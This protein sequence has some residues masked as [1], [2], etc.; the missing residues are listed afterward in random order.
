MKKLIKFVSFIS[1]VI[2]ILL[3][4]SNPLKG[5]AQ[6]PTVATNTVV[7]TETPG[8]DADTEVPSETSDTPPDPSTSFERPLLVISS[9]GTDVDR[10]TPGNDFTLK[11]RLKNDGDSDVYNLLMTFE[12]TDFLPL[13][14]GGV[15]AV[16]FLD[17]GASVEIAQPMR[18][19]A[20]LW[21]YAS[22]TIMASASYTDEDG[23]AYSE[24]FSITIDLRIP[25]YTT[26]QPT[27]MPTLQARAQLV[28]GG[29][30]VDVNPLQSGSIFNLTLDIRNL[31]AVDAQ[32]VTM[33]LGGGVAVPSGTDSTGGQP[34]GGVT[35]TGA[36]LS[37]FAPIG[38][39]NLIYLDEVGVG[40][41]VKA[42]AQLIVNVTANPG[43]Y[44]FKISFTY[45]N[46]KGERVVD[47]QV[48]TLLVYS[49]PKVEI[50]FYRNPGF[51][52]AGQM[53]PV[54]IQMTNLG[55]TTAVLGT[56]MIT[57]EDADLTENTILV[58]SL[59]PG[60]YFTMDAMAMPYVE[61]EM[62]LLVSVSYTDDFNQPR[63]IEQRLTVVVDPM[64]EFEPMPGENNGAMPP[65]MQELPE[66]FFQKVLRFFKGL[67]GLGS[68]KEQP[69]Q[70]MPF[71]GEFQDE[72]P[73]YE[74]P[75]MPIPGPKG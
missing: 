54:P 12:S 10:V 53:N 1:L 43:A 15:L 51:F 22:G 34:A 62:E 9:Y 59:E 40:Q 41:L 6:T 27:A 23:V 24:Q 47:D 4:V 5:V 33:V 70:D 45:L 48:I 20:S 26:P 68:G 28:V 60:G 13:V 25:V 18:A 21:G 32:D 14:S 65:P 30:E 66:T 74:E 52:M 29:Y 55:K 2:L 16:P 69:T 63:K 8:V 50:G 73:Q 31:G 17:T 37:V 67:L 61:G 7:P 64:P 3:A 11:I 57:S 35:G 19:N 49:L 38:T 75:P 39:S 46:E 56:L 72:G 44:P 42:S 58:G 36:D 71:P